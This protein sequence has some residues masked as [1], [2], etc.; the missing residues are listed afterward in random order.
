MVDEPG[1]VPSVAEASGQRAERRNTSQ[2]GLVLLETLPLHLDA[3]DTRLQHFVLSPRISLD[4][5]PPGADT[6]LPD[7][8]ERGSAKPV[9]SRDQ[10]SR[11]RNHASRSGLT[12]KLKASTGLLSGFDCLN[13]M[14][15]I[16]PPRLFG[17]L[18][19]STA[20]RS[21]PSSCALRRMGHSGSQAPSWE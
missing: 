2:S 5:R 8:G 10:E 16:R 13:R 14:G 1:A 12:K 3:L 6:S 11:P 7:S 19:F 17:F 21:S 18:S 20:P 9:E 4:N 15:Q